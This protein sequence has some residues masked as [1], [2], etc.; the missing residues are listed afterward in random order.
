MKS[1]LTIEFLSA[2]LSPEDVSERISRAYGIIIREVLKKRK[3]LEVVDDQK[4]SD[5]TDYSEHNV[6]NRMEVNS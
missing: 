5:K 2:E 1:N 3:S 6:L 4:S